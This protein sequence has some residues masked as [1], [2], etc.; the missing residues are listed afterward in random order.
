MSPATS[1]VT[2]P[3]FQAESYCPAHTSI[4]VGA[5]GVGRLDLTCAWTLM[6]WQ[7]RFASG[8]G[9]QIVSSLRSALRSWSSGCGPTGFRVRIRPRC[10]RFRAA[11]GVEGVVQKAL[12]ST[13]EQVLDWSAEAILAQLLADHLRRQAG[14]RGSEHRSWEAS[15]PILAQDLVDAGLGQVE[16]MLEYKLPVAGTRADVVLSGVDPQTGEDSYVV[17]ELKQWSS[18]ETVYN[19]D[20]I[21]RAH[22]L[23]G[24]QL[25]PITQVR[26]Y[27]KYLTQNVEVLHDRPHAVHGVAYLHNA[28]QNSTSTLRAGHADRFGRMFTG[29]IRKE[30]LEFL[31][32]RVAPA[33]DF[34]PGDRLL[35]SPI[36]SR[37]TLLDFTASKLRGPTEFALLDNQELAYQRVLDSVRLAHERDGKSV[38]IVTGGPGSGKSLIAVTLL[39]E[40][41]RAGK[42]V[43]HATG[44]QAFT[45]SLRK[46]PAKGSTKLKG[47]FQ[48]Y[49]TF[50]DYAK[51][52]LDVLIC[53]EAHRI[54][55]VSTN[56][57]TKKEKRTDRPQVDE[58]IAAAKVPV[59]LLDEHQVVRPDEV[60]T[61][62]EI[63]AHATRA[64]YPVFLIEL[65]GLFRCGGS[66]AYDEWVRRLLG[67]RV[68]GPTRWNG[69]ATFEVRIAQS[70]QEMQDYLRQRTRKG[71]PRGS[72][73][74]TAGRG[75]I[76][77]RTEVSSTMFASN[78][79]LCHGI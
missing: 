68:G 46:Y 49:R 64:G 36:R 55:K 61:V 5:A 71:R 18:A 30:F 31:T 56:R 39:A 79:G 6:R 51:N 35:E 33:A 74:V 28:T 16:M 34:S 20:R 38:V 29:D 7:W 2:G 8:H 45:E 53:D 14:Y 70:P 23:P 47:L 11:L 43:R 26:G 22:G 78:L 41:H 62:E 9:Q 3:W 10:T 32:A 50:A 17:V 37:P 60:G 12:R 77:S 57:F 15:L 4:T 24:E 54:R 76:R 73:L 75:V 67:L 72:P 1:K 58:L 13:A 44:A 69:D 21:V 42:A 63:R 52:E 66:E 40:L 27:C 59:F 65:D 48:Y 19:S 25:H